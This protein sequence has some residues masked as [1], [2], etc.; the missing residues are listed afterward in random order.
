MDAVVT[1]ALSSIQFVAADP[2]ILLFSENNGRR[3]SRKEIMMTENMDLNNSVYLVGLIIFYWM[4]FSLGNQSV[5]SSDN[6]AADAVMA[7]A[8]PTEPSRR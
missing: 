2:L 1:P 6:E 7:P 4:L 8:E 3:R 5:A